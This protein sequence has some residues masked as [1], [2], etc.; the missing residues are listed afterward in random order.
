MLKAIVDQKLA[1]KDIELS[2]VVREFLTKRLGATPKTETAA[3]A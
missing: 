2:K 1:G 3:P